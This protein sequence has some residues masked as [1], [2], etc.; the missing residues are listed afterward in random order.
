MQ[1]T[2]STISLYSGKVSQEYSSNAT[3]LFQKNIFNMSGMLKVTYKVFNRYNSLLVMNWNVLN[4]PDSKYN[5][6]NKYSPKPWH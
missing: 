1:N 2:N 4:I 5:I 3:K 6:P